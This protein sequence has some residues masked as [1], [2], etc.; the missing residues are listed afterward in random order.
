MKKL[1]KTS[2]L[3]GLVFPIMASAEWELIADFESEDS[4]D[5]WTI[6]NRLSR[7][8]VEEWDSSWRIAP[9]Q[10]DELG[11]FALAAAEGTPRWQILDVGIDLG[12][13]PQNNSFTLF[14]E[15]AQTDLTADRAMGLHPDTPDFWFTYDPELPGWRE[16]YGYP[17]YSTT[18]RLGVPGANA[19][20]GTG[21][22]A[23]YSDEQLPL[24][25]YRFWMVVNPL[26][27]TWNLHVQ[28]GEFPDVTQVTTDYSWRNLTFDP[29]RTWRMRI[30]G[31]TSTR[32][33]T[34]APTYLDNMFLDRTGENLTLPPRTG[35]EVILLGPGIFSDYVV[36]DGWV[37]TGD[38]MGWL[39]VD[40][41]PF[42]Y[43][44]DLDSW[45][46]ADGGN[47]SKGAWV[48]VAHSG[49]MDGAQAA[50]PGPGIFSGYALNNGWV[51]TGDWMAMV[52]VDSYP[53]IYM[54]SLNAWAFA[55]EGESS[56]GAWI[57]MFR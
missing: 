40:T 57:Y 36:T 51:D 8:E 1:L 45:A 56:L 50:N 9:R 18:H 37:D 3:A 12:P 38:W 31:N 17:Q 20:N 43:I 21:Y 26:D 23:N 14:Y 52:F 10:F 48:F 53:S 2:L 19:H 4:L 44:H 30:G 11:G 24:V 33:T 5:A 32:T 7:N 39:A 29:L 34:G 54:H 25:W 6:D 28:G 35:G 41:Y 27:F 55:G 49:N 46:Y 47:P 16:N 22:S 13:L 42:F 15:I